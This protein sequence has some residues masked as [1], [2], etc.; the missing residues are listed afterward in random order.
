MFSAIALV[1]THIYLPVCKGPNNVLFFIIK[2]NSPLPK[3]QTPACFKKC[4]KEKTTIAHY[5]KFHCFFDHFSCEHIKIII[6]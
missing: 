6:Y 4:Q 3:K 1:S 5:R 2:K